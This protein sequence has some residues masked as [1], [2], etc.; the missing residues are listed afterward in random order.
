MK[1]DVYFLAYV[2]VNFSIAAAAY[3]A[4]TWSSIPIPHQKRFQGHWEG[5]KLTAVFEV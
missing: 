4:L 5:L 2:L 3:S 1:M